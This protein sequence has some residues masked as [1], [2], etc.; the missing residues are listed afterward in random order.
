MKDNST[1]HCI[2]W[3]KLSDVILGQM[4]SPDFISLKRKVTV[5]TMQNTCTDMLTF[6]GAKPYQ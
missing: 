6:R 1:I 3:M 2:V 4:V 5:V